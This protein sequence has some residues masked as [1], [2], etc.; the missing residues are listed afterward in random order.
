MIRYKKILLILALALAFSSCA[1]SQHSR[2]SSRPNPKPKPKLFSFPDEW[3]RHEGTIMIF[4]AQHAY[5]QQAKAIQAEVAILANAIAKNE[6]VHMF[7]FPD[8]LAQATKLLSST[9][10]VTVGEAYSVDW[11]R[12]T[13]PL[14]IRNADGE[15]R[16][17]C[18]RFNGWGQKYRGWKQDTKVGV[19]IAKAL[20]LPIVSSAFVMEGGAIEIGASAKGKTG[21]LTASCVLNA[22][23]NGNGNS[24]PRAKVEQELKSNLGI[25]RILWLDKGLVPDPITDGHVDGLLKFVKKNTVL[26]HTT[27][28][29]KDPNYAICKDAKKRLV[30]AGLKVIDLPLADD[31]VHMNF[32]IGSGAK[33][34]YVPI[35]GDPKQDQPALKILRKLFASVIAIPAK[36]I[37]E[38]GGGLHCVTQQIPQH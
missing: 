8:D 19:T 15:R 10:K 30:A 32:Y 33:H 35:C 2:P 37:T 29:K 22:N 21:I 1:R 14:I 18:F 16:A 23:R 7:V 27:D 6:P 11:A 3:E 31:I 34:I 4:P 13:A 12:D 5:R 24:W 28:D 25:E 38:A 17:V 9:I 20:K 26:L 36:A